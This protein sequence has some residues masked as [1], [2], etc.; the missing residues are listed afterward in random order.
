MGNITSYVE[1]FR[2]VNF[3]KKPFDEVDSL[4]LS[5]VSY[6][7][8]AD[9]AFAQ[10]D[11]SISLAEL[12]KT[13]SEKI[14]QATTTIKDDDVALLEAL[15]MRGRHGDL[16]ASN[17]IEILDEKAEKQFS[18][19][20]FELRKYE[21][22]IVFRGT[23]NSVTGWKEDMAMSYEEVIPAQKEALQ[24]AMSVMDRFEGRFYLGGHS[25]GGN[26]SVYTAIH[27]PLEYRKRLCGVFDHDGP[28]FVE[29]VYVG[30]DYWKVRSLIRKTVPKS[31]VIGMMWQ[32]DDNYKVVQSDEKLLVQHDPF[33][34]VINNGK[35]VELPEV[36]AFSKY[37]KI[38]LE[39]WVDLLSNQERRQLVDTIFDVI[40]EA[41]IESFDELT[42]E[43]LP[44]VLK[45][46][47]EVSEVA[48]EER[49]LV[50]SAV[51][52]LFLISTEELPAAAKEQRDAT[53]EKYL[54]MLKEKSEAERSEYLKRVVELK[55]E[56]KKRA[57]IKRK[58]MKKA[59]FE[60]GQELNLSREEAVA[61]LANK[62]SIKKDEAQKFI[63][64]IRKK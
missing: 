35:F 5:Q 2:K 42:E 18:A 50:L 38:I 54:Q 57:V 64:E 32:A 53:V 43:T 9:G 48:P 51:R 25:K 8:Y 61:K 17:Y 19:I 47:E 11:F 46:I 60:I 27:L 44:K 41:G 39:R 20:T 52:Q 14:K 62:M 13:D 45:L 26:L 49:S 37:T 30:E 56:T 1:E 34:W 7:N 15:K 3:A 4:V 36:D 58:E 21:Y 29:A 23:D 59:I 55:E 31:S 10:K 12:L 40:Y 22:Y 63:E 24:Y 28:G 16:R 6:Y 33:T